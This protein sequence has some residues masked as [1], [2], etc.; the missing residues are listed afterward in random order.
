MVEEI[1]RIENLE[2]SYGKTPTLK[3]IDISIKKGEF[4][5]IIGPNGSGKSTFAKVITK[6]L[7]DYRGKIFFKEKEMREIEISDF[8]KYVSFLPSFIS[9]YFPYT[10]EEFVLMGRYPHLSKL[11][12]VKKE[13]IEIVKKTLET[14]G[15]IE[16]RNKKVFELSEGEKQ[17]VFLAQVL[18]QN[19]EVI[20]LD[21]P[22]S[23]LDIGHRFK[24]MDILNKLNQE[25]TTI[26]TILHDLNLAS[27]YSSHLFLFKDGTIYKHGK[28][29]E[30]IDYKII[31]DVYQTKV[32][33]YRN[34]HS[35][36]P[37]VFG[38][39]EKLLTS[40]NLRG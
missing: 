21:E 13:D 30:V 1:Y 35:K 9:V 7:K 3:N 37:Y 23:H 10:V 4:I 39:P 32:L 14:L 2:F 6:I 22:T 27:E 29:E 12:S 5:G 33:V 25:G 17:F 11:E 15:I 40:S 24:I 31:E 36:K 8:S 28:A 20:V 34:P 38:I 19:S 26:I 16:L 18:V